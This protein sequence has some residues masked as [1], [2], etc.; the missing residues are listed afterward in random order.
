MRVRVPV[1]DPGWESGQAPR[2]SRSNRRD[3]NPV[4]RSGED[5]GSVTVVVV[6]AIGVVLI[7]LW[8]GL[9]LASAVIATHRARSAA[10]LGAL[11]AAQAI[12]R[13]VAPPEACAV[14]MSVTARNGARPAGCVVAPDGSVTARAATRAG[15]GLLG[16]GSRTA[17][18]TARAG[19]S[20]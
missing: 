15:L 19:P 12:Q 18:A 5:R 16:A 10:D 2:R 7:L 11:A 8:G 1:Q 3:G 17:T 13:G 9:A 4:A 6:A 20:P 14:G